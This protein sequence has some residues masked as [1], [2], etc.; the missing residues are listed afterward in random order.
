M[1]TWYLY[2]VHCTLYSLQVKNTLFRVQFIHCTTLYNKYSVQWI[3]GICTLYT[4]H[5]VHKFYFN[6]EHMLS[7][8]GLCDKLGSKWFLYTAH[9]TLYTCAVCSVQSIRDMCTLFT[10]QSIKSLKSIKGSNWFSYTVN[11]TEYSA[12]GIFVHCTV[13]IWYLFTAYES[14]LRYLDIL[15]VDSWSFLRGV[16]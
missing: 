3:R 10:A 14:L 13:H 8:N 15:R 16:V 11:C 4:V 12:Y 5:C 6:S 2:T 9:C 7:F 1:N